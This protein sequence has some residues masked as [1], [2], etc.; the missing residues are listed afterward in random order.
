MKQ[1]NTSAR[2]NG[3]L[4]GNAA[5]PGWEIENLI[6]APYPGF[7]FFT[8]Q[9]LFALSDLKEGLLVMYPKA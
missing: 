7:A 3:L 5:L 4:H 2:G 6:L 1:A 9:V 8:W